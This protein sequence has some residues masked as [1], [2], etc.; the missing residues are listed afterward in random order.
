M[1]KN[2]I[3]EF[4][5][6][7]QQ[8][9][10]LATTDNDVLAQRLRGKNLIIYF[11]PRDN[12]PGCTL[13]ANDFAKHYQELQ[14]LQVE[15]V[16]VSRDSLA[17]HARFKAKHDLPFE[18]ISDTDE[19]VC[20]LFEVLNE[21]KLVRSTFL[22]SRHGNLAQEWRKVSPVSIHVQEVLASVRAPEK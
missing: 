9:G 11:Y 2:Y 20:R 18:L 1:S 7:L 13:E 4:F 12:T 22:I 10:C 8:K 5:G 16:G 21:G 17:S 15:V 6:I 3:E 19:A 14:K